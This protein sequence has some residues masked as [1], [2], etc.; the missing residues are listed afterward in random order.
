MSVTW[1]ATAS[2]RRLLGWLLGPVGQ[3]LGFLQRFRRKAWAFNTVLFIG[4]A[5]PTLLVGGVPWPVRLTATCAVLGACVWEAVA[6]RA[7]RFPLWADVLETVA[8]AIVSWRWPSGRP[9]LVFILAFVLPSLGFRALFS[10]PWQAVARS[11]ATVLGVYAGDAAEPSLSPSPSMPLRRVPSVLL[12]AVLVAYLAWE[13]ATALRRKET[14]AHCRR[15][16]ARLNGELSVARGRGDVYAAVLRA[17]LDLLSGRADVRVIIWDEAASLR[18]TVA[19]GASADAVHIG[20]GQPLTMLPQVRDAFAFGESIYLESF[21]ADALRAVLGFDP[22]PGVV[23]FVPLRHREQVRGLSVAGRDAIPASVRDEIEDVARAGELAL[24]AIALTQVSLDELRERS[25]RDPR[26]GLANP[27]LLRLR[28]EQALAQPDHRVALLLIHVDHFKAIDDFANEACATLARRLAGFVREGDTV[29]QLEGDRFAILL[30][31]VTDPAMA[32]QIASRVISRFDDPLPGIVLGGAT[33]LFVRASIGV[34]LSGP[35][36]RDPNDLLRNAGVALDAASTAGGGTYRLFEPSMRASIVDRLELES[37]LAGALDRD[38]FILH[39]Q[40]IV[41]LAAPRQI[42]GV[43]ALVRW[44]HPRR[45]R[46]P[47]AQFIPAA[48][49]TGVITHIGA[50]V[51]RQGCQQL[52]AWSTSQPKLGRLTLNVNLSPVQLAQPDLPATISKTIGEVGVDPARV[53]L[54]LTENCLVE[55]TQAN[56]ERLQALKTIG[57]SLAVDDFGTGF[58]SLSYLHRFPFDQ[59]KIDRSF[60]HRVDTDES[61]AA[62]TTS[63]LRMGDALHLASVAEGVETRGE[64]DWLT[65]AGC[66][67]AQGYYFSAPMAPDRLLPRLTGGQPSP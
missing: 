7:Q 15:V 10:S 12:T 55:D 39:Y 47:P 43:E 6:L 21:D 33:G 26:T 51:L 49:E 23:F 28:L 17:V 20:G 41:Q 4:L 56:L 61:T 53:V 62:L 11:V 58:C 14:I 40:P 32:A 34:A 35:G 9:F 8:V 59:I 16:A 1:I 5:I 24:G 54:E 3:D 13:A 60:V 63:I 64:A 31:G 2:G 19:A 25:Y 48:E 66:D 52:R 22:T 42:S 36:A 44:N 45:G 29:A 37:D 46:V 67:A 27:S 57:L 30:E 38:E 50:W 18:P 65:T